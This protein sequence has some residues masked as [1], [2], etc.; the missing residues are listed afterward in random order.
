MTQLNLDVRRAT[1]DDDQYVHKLDVTYLEHYWLPDDWQRHASNEGFIFVGTANHVP[2]ATLVCDLQ[3]FENEK[4]VH[5][6]K[7]IVDKRF[8]GNNLGKK[9]L[10]VAYELG[11]HYSCT[12]LAISVPHHMTVDEGNCVGWLDKMGFRATKVLPPIDRDG[13]P[14]DVYLF[15]RKIECSMG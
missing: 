11:L 5:I 14:E 10:A 1:S 13:E 3:E 9:L 12:Q 4:L 15:T 6:Y 2:V 8:R 7:V